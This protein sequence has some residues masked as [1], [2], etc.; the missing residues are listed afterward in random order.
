METTWLPSSSSSA[1]EQRAPSKT[2]E[3]LATMSRRTSSSARAELMALM[4]SC[5][6]RNSNTLMPRL[7]AICCMVP[8]F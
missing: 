8:V 6:V 7:V 3:A 2:C 4:P 1:T 5:N